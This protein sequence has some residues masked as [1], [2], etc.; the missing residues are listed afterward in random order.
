MF[1]ASKQG[2]GNKITNDTIVFFL[3]LAYHR[4]VLVNVDETKQEI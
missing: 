1:F 2:T 3:E 4:V